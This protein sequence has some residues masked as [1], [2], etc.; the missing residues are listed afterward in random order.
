M[1]IGFYLGDIKKPLS[2]GGLTF[3]SSVVNE[4]ISR[5]SDHE[6]VFYY[7]GKDDI[8]EDTENAKFVSLKYFYKPSFSFCPFAVKLNKVPL[9]SFNYRL[10]KDNI[11]TVFF[12]T[13]YLFEH[14]EIT[15]FAIIRDVAHRVLPMFPEYS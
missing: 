12:L 11:D 5:E 9:Y 2:L 7:F 14:V 4:I 15:Y 8:F 6:F 3:E 10:K 1:K 13:P